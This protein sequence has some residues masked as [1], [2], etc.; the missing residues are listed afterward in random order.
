MKG[1][2]SSMCRDPGAVKKQDA[3]KDPKSDLCELSIMNNKQNGADGV[4][5]QTKFCEI[6][7]L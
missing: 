5:M 2:E 3:L 1:S 4:E 6:L 7:K